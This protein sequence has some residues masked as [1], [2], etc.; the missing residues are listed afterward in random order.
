MQTWIARTTVIIITFCIGISTAFLWENYQ[1]EALIKNKIV[2]LTYE[3]HDAQL[4]K[5]EETLNRILG[6][7]I[8]FTTRSENFS[9][10]KKEF[11]EKITTNSFTIISID[12][13]K[14]N[15]E[16]VGSTFVVNFKLK[17]RTN[18]ESGNIVDH[19]ANYQYIYEK[20]QEE[21][22]L[23]HISQN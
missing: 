7:E 17:I 16:I 14:M 20:Q 9:L 15:A 13:E 8:V 23:T 6:N 21:W 22:K 10:N 19:K 3:L 18:F 12:T 4:L 5:N 1:S 11:I 2:N